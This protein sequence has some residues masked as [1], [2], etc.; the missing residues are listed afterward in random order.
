MDEIASLIPPPE[1]PSVR[2]ASHCFDVQF[3]PREPVLAAATITG[4]LELHKFD[5]EAGTS[6]LCRS[7]R[8]HR[9]SCRSARFLPLDG[10]CA[11]AAE[12][13]SS[14]SGAG[15][16]AVRIA[17][18]AADKLAA[19][20]D[21]ERGKRVWK[22]RLK[23][24]GNALLPL[25]AERFV[26]G[27]DE[28]GIAVY[29][30][31]QKKATLRYAENEDYISDLALGTDQYSLCATGGDGTLAVYDLR[32]AG[33]KGLLA[34]SDFQ[35]DEF[36]SLVILRSG[37][38]VICGSQTGALCIFTWG[39]FGTQKDRIKGHPMSVDA[40][41]K[42]SE[43]SILTGSSDGK[44]RAVSVY[45]RELGSHVLGMIAEHGDYPI[46]RLALSPCGGFLASASHGQ[47][48]VRMW[49]ME[50]AKKMFAG[51]DEADGE[52]GASAAE[53]DSSDEDEAPRKKQ[54]KKRR[55]GPGDEVTQ[56]AAV[57]FGDL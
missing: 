27:D 32:K 40:M 41:V 29:D 52:Q 46:E 42:V 2:T 43:D 50:A 26:T 53:G 38:K 34:M 7:I 9:D 10:A 17:S 56:R 19:V 49:S 48:A 22:A 3:H 25:D 44:V 57:F 21:V 31:R 37:T 30:V 6:E 14:G 54:K 15:R 8:C 4:A 33:T 47:P 35:E 39:D 5:F 24:A 55:K 23:A 16:T 20:A 51:E 45:S 13:G 28:G 36:L 18:V 1:P 12:G 11:E